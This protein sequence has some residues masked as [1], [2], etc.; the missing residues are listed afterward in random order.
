MSGILSHFNSLVSDKYLKQVKGL[1]FFKALSIV[2]SFLALSILVRYLGQ[3]L[4]GV[5]ATFLSTVLWIVAFDF[6]IGS[7]LRNKVK[8]NTLSKNKD[9]VKKFISTSYISLGVIGFILFLFIYGFIYFGQ[10][11]VILN[12]SLIEEKAFDNAA[13]VMILFMMI[14]YI[15]LLSHQVAYAMHFSQL[16]EIHQFSTNLFFF[17]FVYIIYSFSSQ[18]INLILMAYGFSLFLS[19]VISQ[20]LVYKK[21]GTRLQPSF[22]FFRIRKLKS[23]LHLGGDFMIIQ[24]SL[25]FILSTDKIIISNFF[26]TS[27]TTVYDLIYKLLLCI[28]IFQNIILAPIW[29]LISEH[30]KHRN[31]IKI[32]K[33]LRNLNWIMVPITILSLSL[34]YYSND[35]IRIWTGLEISEGFYVKYS[36]AIFIVILCWNNIYGTF[37]NGISKIKYQSR[38][39]LVGAI[40]NIPLSVFFVKFL[41]MGV[42]GVVIASIISISI[43]AL[44][45]PIMAYRIIRC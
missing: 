11:G 39:L 28:L 1:L 36:I 43:F 19:S 16:S 5:W 18:N 23:L 4:Y 10:W 6:G 33:I 8:E 24:I 20:G 42:E 15:A 14:N 27:V 35:M 2:F 32:R 3:S 40:I 22:I 44:V 12:T 41:N 34:A 13:V 45:G 21:Y 25:L 17:L 37:S 29:T 26:S 30:Y 9:A 7:S 38:S 31:F